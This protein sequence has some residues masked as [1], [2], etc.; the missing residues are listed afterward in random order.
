MLEKGDSM[1]RYGKSLWPEDA[2][3]TYLLDLVLWSRI[4][5][6]REA[7]AILSLELVVCFPRGSRN[8]V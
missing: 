2:R 7:V 1:S 4:S 3:R 5:R 6:P 8:G